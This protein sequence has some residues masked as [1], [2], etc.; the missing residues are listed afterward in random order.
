MP[1]ICGLPYFF[2]LRIARGKDSL[3]LGNIGLHTFRCWL[4]CRRCS[5]WGFP[6]CAAK[7]QKPYQKRNCNQ[8]PHQIT[9]ILF[10]ILLPNLDSWRHHS[11]ELFHH[12]GRR[13]KALRCLAPARRYLWQHARQHCAR[14]CR[15]IR[16]HRGSFSGWF[17]KYLCEPQSRRIHG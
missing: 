9:N 4:T 15:F 12:C 5:L 8:E 17:K 1:V 3:R 10:A 13:C 14:L 7:N 2:F 16:L 6:S 11:L